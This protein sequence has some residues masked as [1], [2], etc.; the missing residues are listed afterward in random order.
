MDSLDLWKNRFR[1]GTAFT[2]ISALGLMGSV[3]LAAQDAS[4]DEEE[5]EEVVVTG[6]RIKR[7]G[8]SAPSPVTIVDSEAISLQGEI[9]L[10]N[11]LNQLPALGSTR[12]NASATGFIGT[13]GTSN[14]DLRRLGINR[15]LVLVNGRR[16][17]GSQAGSAA[18]DINSIPQEL[19][20]RVEV[21]TG[22]ASA[23]YGADAVTGVVNFVTKKDFE[24]VS[25]FG[26][27]GQADEGDAFSYTTRL[28]AGSNFDDDKGNAVFSVEWAETDGFLA[29]DRSFRR[30]NFS[31][32]PNPTDGDTPANSND[33]IP[34]QIL[35]EGVSLDFINA[36]GIFRVPGRAASD[37]LGRD[38]VVD[39]NGFR[40]FD[41]GENIG[42]GRSIN[43]T[44]DGILLSDIGGS[45][46][47][48]LQRAIVTGALNYKFR[49]E[50]NLFIET[51]YVNSQSASESGTGAF[52]IFSISINSDNAFLTDEQRQFFVDQGTDTLLVS[53]S[54]QEVPRFDDVERQLFRGVIGFDGTFDNGI[55]YDTSFVYGRATVTN[56]QGNNRINDRFNAGIDAV[57]DN[58]GNIVCRSSIDPDA[59]SGLPD[60][61]VNGCVPIN[62][63][64]E[65]AISP[66]AAEFAFFNDS[67]VETLEQ[68]V[69]S[70]NISGDSEAIGFSLPA[71]AI[72][73]AI[74]GEYREEDSTSLTTGI[75]RL[76][77]TFLNVIPPEA[78][79][80]DV[81]EVYG[82][83]S[84]PVLNDVFLAKQLSV[85]AAIRFSDYSTVGGTTT[86]S[87][88]VNWQPVEDLRFRG[89]YSQSVRAPNI[90]ELFGPQSQTFFGVDDPCDVDFLDQGSPTR[91]ANCAALGLGPDFQEDETRGTQPGLQ[92]GNPNLEEETADTFTVGAVFTPS[93]APGLTITV[94]YFDIE[95]S[96]AID[97]ATFQ[98]IFDNCVDAPN[99]NNAFCAAIQRDSSGQF[100]S[101]NRTL[102]N[103]A[104]LEVS[105]IDFEVGYNFDLEDIGVGDL[106]NLR[107]R[108]LGTYLI[109]RTDFPFQTAPD[110]F[111]EEAGELGDP[112]WAVNTSVTWTYG[113]FNLNYELRFQDSQLLVEQ[114]D[115]ATDP[116]LQFPF[117][118]G[119][120]WTHD[121][122][123]GYK[124]TDN[125]D[126]FAGVNNLSQ[127]FPRFDL[128]GAGVDSAIFDTV[129]RF[130]YG[131]IRAN[132]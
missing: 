94:D 97:S 21:L 3:S 46:N 32:R 111:D 18:V 27:A 69:V 88:G 7:S 34:D 105:G 95:I 74:G 89:T 128:S 30:N 40:P 26:Q 20:E 109:D 106:G 24:G 70:L 61:A 37:P 11:I 127:E 108:T 103:I 52:D 49:D 60:F 101:A 87:V 71:G 118:T 36:G 93:F 41:F 72:S 132:F 47:G 85:D 84:V 10:A 113:K 86:W 79:G 58:D 31:I 107:I 81:A 99:I 23:I 35:F 102:N 57:F 65:N 124:L 59:A 116:D 125:V 75:D 67:L 54:S 55:S 5:V 96:D 33:G 51:K 28:I 38:F 130:Y 29:N 39:G 126:I 9:N 8:A 44:G 83:V 100:V 68:K 64:G 42:G 6:S 129:G 78:G 110:Q 50:L 56:I 19:V 119:D 13:T 114:D 90:A 73:W 120:V 62:I 43:G 14:L 77:L 16:H 53:R 76:G 17:V 15:T 117:E 2:L 25:V 123:V 112:E 131:G 4:V 63:L 66:E 1:A 92:G 12:T 80:F 22:G 91:A 45:A 104:G 48:E 82:E 98:Q 122:R 121:I 115:L